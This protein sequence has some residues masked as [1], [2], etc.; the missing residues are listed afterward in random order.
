MLRILFKPFSLDKWLV[1]GFCVWL[2][3]MFEN[4]GGSFNL[5]LGKLSGSGSA[6]NDLGPIWPW[7]K[8]LLLSNKPLYARL[9][10]LLGVNPGTLLIVFAG[11]GIV[12]IIGL[13]ITVTVLWLKS[14]FEFILI[15]NLA[16]NKADITASWKKF[17]QL[18]NS[19]FAFR[20]V[21]WLLSLAVMAF[22]ALTS[23]LCFIT[24]LKK[25]AVNEK[26]VYPG[27]HTAA[28]IILMFILWLTVSLILSLINFFFKEFV[29][30]IM[31]KKR[32][33]AVRAC[34]YFFELLKEQT[35]LFIR[36]LLMKIAVYLAFG[37]AVIIIIVM[38]CCLAVLPLI[39]PYVGTVI[40]LPA[41]VF[42]RLLGM[43]MLAGF[44]SEFSVF[45]ESEPPPSPPQQS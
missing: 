9:A 4:L 22:L 3:Y 32:N 8:K 39:I 40:L 12:L 10:D 14:R 7:L 34:Y 41:F 42:F 33:N 11:I 20:I 13:I 35:W 6:G 38:T 24:W 29:L 2:A 18:G 28:A 45:P 44:G 43:E 5:N 21:V 37:V 19:A 1:L 17:K 15:E 36:Y 16:L 27:W 23:F 30:V 25:C 26:L 31:Y